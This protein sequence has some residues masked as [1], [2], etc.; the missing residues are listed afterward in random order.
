MNSLEYVPKRALEPRKSL[1]FERAI[2]PR[3]T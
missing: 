3:P 1:R 2:H